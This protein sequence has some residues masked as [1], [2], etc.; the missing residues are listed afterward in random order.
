MLL[1]GMTEILQTSLPYDPWAE[2]PLP[3]VQP[4]TLAEWLTVDLA[5]AGQMAARDRLLETAR[6]DVLALDETARPAAKE[7][8]DLV[9]S[10]TYPVRLVGADR[11]PARTG[12]R[13]VLIR[14]T[15]WAR[16]DGWCKKTCAFCKSVATN[17]C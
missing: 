13:W 6:A 3:G 8:L 1:R 7:L 9:L 15:H 16:W 12:S 2:R 17:M 14:A 4:T 11:S 10:L 5:F